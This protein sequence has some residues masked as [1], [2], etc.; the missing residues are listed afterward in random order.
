MDIL[1]SKFL[2]QRK[3]DRYWPKEDTETYSNIEV[4]LLKEESMANYTVRAFKIKHLKV[5][6]AKR[7]APL[8]NKRKGF[9]AFQKN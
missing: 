1:K 6:Y 8:N 9:R 4:N 3:C 7:N 2:F 5:S